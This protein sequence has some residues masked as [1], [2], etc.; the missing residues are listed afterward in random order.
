MLRRLAIADAI[1]RLRSGCFW[2]EIVNCRHYWQCAGKR[3]RR[4]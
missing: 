4:Y 3:W 1:G 2:C